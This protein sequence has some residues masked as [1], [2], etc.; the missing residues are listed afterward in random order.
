MEGAII[1]LIELF[2]DCSIIGQKHTLQLRRMFGIYPSNSITK[3]FQIIRKCVDS[4]N[5]DIKE[6]FIRNGFPKINEGLMLEEFGSKIKVICHA[7][8]DDSFY[9][10]P[11]K[12]D[13]DPE[14]AFQKLSFKFKDPP[15]ETANENVV[16]KPVPPIK[17]FN[18]EWL[19]EA[20]RNSLDEDSN[21]SAAELSVSVVHLLKTT[22]S[23]E[24][25]QNEVSFIQSLNFSFF[26]Y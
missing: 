13:D 9:A 7:P 21:I 19:T 15:K 22:K 12:E 18:R 4:L 25:I 2:R 3:A 16:Y 10:I 6:D 8:L 24:E 17:K 5:D 23:D 26:A 20:L 11:F 1:F 14:D